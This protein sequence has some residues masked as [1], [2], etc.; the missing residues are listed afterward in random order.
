MTF[1][2]VRYNQRFN[3][4]GAE[5]GRA[6]VQCGMGVKLILS[7]EA[8]KHFSAAA[9]DDATH[10]E[11]APA[12]ALFQPACSPFHPGAKGSKQLLDQPFRAPIC[13]DT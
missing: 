9:S 8:V 2:D 1:T 5:P 6:V 4:H 3:W 7:M 13:R 12:F 11:S 10:Q